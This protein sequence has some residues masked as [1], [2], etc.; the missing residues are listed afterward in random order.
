MCIQASLFLT[1]L[2]GHCSRW[3]KEKRCK[4]QSH[5]WEIQQEGTAGKE[6]KEKSKTTGKKMRTGSGSKCAQVGLRAPKSANQHTKL[7]PTMRCP[8][9]H[10]SFNQCLPSTGDLVK[11]F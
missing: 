4:G 10:A 6:V 1:R 9:A 8:E 3:Q 5:R 2:N 11:K 7:C